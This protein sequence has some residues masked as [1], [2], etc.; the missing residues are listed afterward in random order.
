MGK[1][2][3]I[4]LNSVRN[5]I[6]RLFLTGII[7]LA[8]VVATIFLLFWVFQFIDNL[9]QP[10][11]S[12]VIGRYIYGI[13]FVVLVALVFLIGLIA[14]SVMG[15]KLILLGEHLLTRVPLTR[16]VYTMMKEITDSF[17]GDATN[18]F[19]QVV[20]VEFP[21]KGVKAIGFITNESASKFEER[22]IGVYIPGCPNP[23]SGTFLIVRENEIVRT[24][25]SVSDAMKMV[26]SAGRASLNDIARE[27]PVGY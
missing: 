22:L 21:R 23:T 13:G 15:N 11:L 5:R 24:S 7:I 17:S 12:F 14:E 26:I 8:P 16:P 1:A 18:G 3:K 27:W 25:L 19:S 10:L 9:L 4:T 2:R 20:L 6:G